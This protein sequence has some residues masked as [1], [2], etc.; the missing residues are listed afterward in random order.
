MLS[1]RRFVLAATVKKRWGDMIRELGSPSSR[2]VSLQPLP[3]AAYLTGTVGSTFFV[4]AP[5]AE[6]AVTSVTFGFGSVFK[7]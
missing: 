2:P 4:S 5:Q 3:L 7:C 1:S 6:A